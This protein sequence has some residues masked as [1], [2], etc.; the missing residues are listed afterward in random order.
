MN[1]QKHYSMIDSTILDRIEDYAREHGGFTLKMLGFAGEISVNAYSFPSSFD[2]DEA[3]SQLKKLKYKNSGYLLNA[4]YRKLGIEE[5]SKSELKVYG[6]EELEYWYLHIN[7]DIPIP[8]ELQTH[9]KIQTH[10]FI[11]FLTGEQVNDGSAFK[12]LYSGNIF[13]DYTREFSQAIYLNIEEVDKI[14]NEKYQV[15]L[16]QFEVVIYGICKTIGIEI[17]EELA[18]VALD[19]LILLPPTLETFQ[20]LL[21]LLTRGGYSDSEYKKDAKKLQTFHQKGVENF[22]MHEK[23][24][25]IL[26]RYEMTYY[27]DWKFDPED[28]ESGIS[29][30]LGEEFRFEYPDET[31]SHELFPYIRSE[32]A[33]Q[34]LIMMNMDTFGDSYLFFVAHSNDVNNILELAQMIDLKVEKI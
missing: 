18:S 2:Y 1:K 3:R 13:F 9:L 20:S 22:D 27:S 10:N 7:F 16:S 19:R 8:I 14:G 29:E 30:I 17:P 21:K 28:I 26:E 34:E 23:T 31:Y 25:A 12:L 11:S 5:L 4:A 33:K 32:L 24:R 15:A 6:T